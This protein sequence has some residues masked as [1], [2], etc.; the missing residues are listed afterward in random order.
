MNIKRA[1]WVTCKDFPNI[2]GIVT[3]VAK[4]KEW[5][6]IKNDLY[7][8]NGR[9]CERCGSFKNIQIHHKTYERIFN[10]EPN[11]LEILCG[12]CHLGEHNLI[13]TKPKIPPA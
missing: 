13:K 6:D 5:A 12:G 1:D 11:D 10:E 4:S 8:I 2:Y 3:R 7:E 9:K